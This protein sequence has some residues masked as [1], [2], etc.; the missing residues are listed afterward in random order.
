MAVK[1]LRFIV[2]EEATGDVVNIVTI[3]DGV[4][5]PP[6]YAGCLIVEHNTRR[7]ARR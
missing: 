1:K 7:S 2:V 6:P 5:W 3:A 4:A